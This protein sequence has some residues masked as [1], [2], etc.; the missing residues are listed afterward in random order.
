MRHHRGVEP[1]VTTVDV[2]VHTE[3]DVSATDREYGRAKLERILDDAPKPVLHARLDLAVAPDPARDRP[4]EAKAGLDLNGRLLRARVAAGT[5][6]E[7]VDLLDA[8][9]RQRLE[10]TRDRAA[11]ARL[12]TRDDAWHHGDPPAPR[13]PYFPRP[14]E[15]R[16]IVRGTTLAPGA[17]TPEEAV[18][19]ALLL[20]VDF[21]LF[22]NADTDT[23][24]VVFRLDGDWQ[25]MTP[26]DAPDTETAVPTATAEPPWTTLDD[27]RRLLDL[28]DE[29]FVFFLDPETARG[30]VL[31]RRY[32][33]HYGLVT[34][35]ERETGAPPAR[36]AVSVP[37]G[38][39]PGWVNAIARW[40]LVLPG[41][42]RLLGRGL[43]LVSF[44]G[45]RSGARYTVPV[46]YRRDGDTVV[47]LT[48]T[49]RTWWRNLVD[50]PE[51]E[52]RLAGERLTGR[53]NV[54]VDDDVALA[55]LL[56][57]FDGSPRD[58]K[59]YGVPLDPAGR[60]DERVVRALLPQ[61]VVVRVR[62]A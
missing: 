29:P 42:R 60:P 20:G 51:L 17:I 27:A 39:P 18:A 30:S 5:V 33:G 22:T 16:E 7:A 37:T 57:F 24:N 9:L 12:R 15:E 21:F 28:G 14:P 55:T 38:A 53:A 50:R 11:A 56:D 61:I 54:H 1:Q 26:S 6:T 32:D 40:M 41:L 23:D 59:P 48:K 10:R 31:Y 62:L 43:A 52:L 13:P 45:R 47:F 44:T 8:R 25:L 19:E 58:A 49:F 4:A 2:V 3:G 46:R 34:T 36:A 35:E